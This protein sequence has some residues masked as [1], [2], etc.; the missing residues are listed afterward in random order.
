[1][2][3]SDEAYRQKLR[4]LC[5]ESLFHF[6]EV[7]INHTLP[8]DKRLPLQPFHKEVLDFAQDPTIFRHGILMPRYFGKS[9][10]ITQSKPIWDWLHD[11]DVRI[12][13]AAETMD[14]AKTFFNFT[15]RQIEINPVLHW[16]FPETIIT[17]K[18]KRDYRWSSEE[19][20]M[21]RKGVWAQP[22][23]KCCGVGASIQGYHGDIIYLDDLIG[24]NAM[25]SEAIRRDTELWYNNVEELLH[26][27]D[28]RGQNPSHIYL[29]GTHWAPGDLYC[30]VQENDDS[31]IWKKIKA[32]VDGIPTWPEKLSAEEIADMKADPSLAMKFYSQMQNDPQSTDLTDFKIEYLKYYELT[33]VDDKPA[34][35]FKDKL[36]EM[37]TVLISALDI[38]ATIDP[39]FSESGLKKTSRTA[40]VIVG[41]HKKTN[42]KFVLE[43]WAKRITEPRHLYEQIMKFH[44]KYRPRRW[45]C[46]A[47]QAQ[48]FILR[49][50]R[51]YFKEKNI[52]I[53][54]TE[55]PRDMG[56]GGG[57]GEAKNIRIRALLD[58]F[59]MGQIYILE[60]QKYLKGEYLSFPVGDTNDL[61]D[62]L[63]YHK[64]YYWANVNYKRLVKED[65]QKKSKFLMSIGN[66]RTGYG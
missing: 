27:P 12:L 61:M 34:I 18:H 33:T 36:G 5:Y 32:E 1:M 8:A 44:L 52:Y 54:I 31:Y 24:K 26:Q 38:R 55:L 64:K 20:E 58:E 2:Q 43:A 15:T 3:S 45:G 37:Q 25:T 9:H 49:G 7:V 11:N 66:S 21:P 46:E 4:L 41:V 56:V 13:I 30:K 62:A 39:A 51:E 35:R 40:I 42:L 23:F 16:L 29:I 60:S 57:R 65:R 14:K 10:N 19:L 47:F 22:T 6:V 59:A 17:E 53:P 50:I 28:P 48:A 63:A